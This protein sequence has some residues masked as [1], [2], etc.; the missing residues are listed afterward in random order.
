[1]IAVVVSSVVG[2]GLCSAG[3]L[4]LANRFAKTPEGWRWVAELSVMTAI[5]AITFGICLSRHGIAATLLL[6]PLAVLGSAAAAVDARQLRLPDPLVTS[7]ALTTIPVLVLARPILG[8]DPAAV[9]PVL[10]WGLALSGTLLV[11]IPA[12]WGWGDAK[13]VPILSCWIGIAGI[14]AA[15]AAATYSAM[16]IAMLAVWRSHW[17]GAG[18]AIPY[19]PAIVASTLI[20][21]ATA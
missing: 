17:D 4:K 11:L 7:L 5:L 10:L 19:G 12:G 13:L 2:A 6:L 16:S 1:M 20:A 18:T 14:P 3:G 9:N 21:W 15:L 8:S